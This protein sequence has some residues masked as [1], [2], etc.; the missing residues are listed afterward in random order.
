MSEFRDKSSSRRFAS[1]PSCGG[2]NTGQVVAEHEQN[3]EV[4]RHADRGLCPG[5]ERHR[6]VQRG[7]PG[8]Q[9]GR[10]RRGL[11]DNNGRDVD[12]DQA[13][14]QEE[15]E[16]H[17]GAKDRHCRRAYVRLEGLAP[18]FQNCSKRNALLFTVSS[19][20]FFFKKNKKIAQTVCF[21]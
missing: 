7:L 13:R 4:L 17:G 19:D 10:L 3:L 8:E 5:G 6:L 16:A 15:E 14:Q 12:D 11:V 20:S 21:V 18:L 1:S 9:G 2:D